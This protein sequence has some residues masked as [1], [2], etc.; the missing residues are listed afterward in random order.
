[1][2]FEEI[3]RRLEF[4]EEEQR[5][6]KA[7]VS[8]LQEQINGISSDLR[9]LTQQIREMQ[10]Q[11][12]PLLSLP[13]RLEQLESGI[14]RQREELQRM[15]TDV[16]RKGEQKL[17]EALQHPARSL[18]ALQQELEAIRSAKV[19]LPVFEQKIKARADETARLRDV[20]DDLREK[21]S[22][23]IQ[24]QDEL[25]TASQVWEEARRRDL[26][27][28][29]TLQ[30]ELSSLRKRVDEQQQKM[31][32]QN[33]AF[34][35]LNQRVNEVLASE[36][37]RRREFDAAIQKLQVMEVDLQR[38]QKKMEDIGEQ[39]RQGIAD[40]DTKRAQVEEALRAVQ[41]AENIFA[42]LQQRL[43][44]RL[45]EI[46]E[47][48]RLNEERMRQEW[49]AF[50]AEEQKRWTAFTLLQEQTLS[51]LRKLL[52]NLEQKQ[53]ELSQTTETLQENFSQSIDLVQEQ[54]QRL[55]NLAHDWLTAYK[56]LFTPP[57]TKR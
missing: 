29:T 25:R 39:F 7:Q 11:L 13:A 42:E 20:I 31:D 24:A 38:Y 49:V 47:I 46:G 50:R 26:G 55:M 2:E 28:I 56:R 43:E 12:S 21:I 4:I 6:N 37:E 35:S 36:T 15:I 48:Q 22:Q 41:R 44:R 40:L 17:Q 34:R 1:M 8:V 52:G 16:E 3:I 53:Q 30:G 10:K 45:G 51:D 32:L 9:I 14:Q 19:D 27:Q 5:K 54:M 23:A 57:S 33:D 18:E